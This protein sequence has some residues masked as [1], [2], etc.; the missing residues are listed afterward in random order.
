MIAKFNCF[1]P[2]IYGPMCSEMFPFTVSF[3]IVVYV[4]DPFLTLSGREMQQS[5]FEYSAALVE[6]MITRVWSRKNIRYG[7]GLG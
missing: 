4:P 3:N 1:V 2:G 5:K 6:L 7:C